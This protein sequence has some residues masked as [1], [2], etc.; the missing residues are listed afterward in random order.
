MSKETLIQVCEWPEVEERTRKGTMADLVIESIKKH[1]WISGKGIQQG[2]A[3][4][5]GGGSIVFDSPL[6]GS[7]RM[8]TFSYDSETQQ[9]QGDYDGDEYVVPLFKDTMLE[10]AVWSLL[11]RA[12][13]DLC[14]EDQFCTEEELKKW[15][16][17]GAL[18]EKLIDA[19]K[20]I[21]KDTVFFKLWFG[22][23][24]NACW[25]GEGVIDIIADSMD[26]FGG[27]ECSVDDETGG[28]AKATARVINESMPDGRKGN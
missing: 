4:S 21:P 18:E 24:V 3:L 7:L 25:L 15:K 16:A 20:D 8:N 10:D 12:F 14:D 23:H 11:A 19:Y 5:F 6:P 22:E 28:L 13:D 1:I 17:E 27:E 2:K 26:D 9:E